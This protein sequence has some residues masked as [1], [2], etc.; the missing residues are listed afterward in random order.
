MYVTLS[1]IGGAGAQF[2]DNNG[3]PLAG[4]LLYTYFA[5]TTTPLATFTDVTGVTANTNPIVLNAAGRVP[6]NEIWQYTGQAYKF[7]LTTSTGV[8]VWTADNIAN[9]FIVSLY[10]TIG[11]GTAVTFSLP[12]TP[13]SGMTITIYINGVYQNKLSYSFS[14]PTI[15][16]SQAPPI[17]STIEILYV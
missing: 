4:G 2:F 16:F 1:P 17:T 14:G 5:G 10:N 11:D 9:G 3:V 15:T 6:S 7:V 12:T 13:V 8:L